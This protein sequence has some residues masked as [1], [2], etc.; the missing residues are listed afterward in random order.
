MASCAEGRW[1]EAI[2]GLKAALEKYKGDELQ[3]KMM[4]TLASAHMYAK[5]LDTAITIFETIVKNFPD[6]ESAALSQVQADKLRA[7]RQKQNEGK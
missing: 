7:Q 4:F 3:P 6:T 2:D 1:G 5:D